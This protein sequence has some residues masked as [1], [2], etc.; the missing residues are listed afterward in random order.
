[1]NNAATSDGRLGKIEEAEQQADDQ[2][3]QERRTHAAI[4][5]SAE[6]RG[7]GQQLNGDDRRLLQFAGPFVDERQGPEQPCADDHRPAGEPR[8]EDRIKYR[9]TQ[10]D[11][12]SSGPLICVNT[13]FL[14]RFSSDRSDFRRGGDQ[15][16]DNPAK[17]NS[18]ST[19]L[20]NP[21]EFSLGAEP[22]AEAF[23]YPFKRRIHSD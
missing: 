4:I 11:W 12:D 22:T 5:V 3:R 8:D 17:K 9:N 15:P 2:P 18:K 16:I 21:G 14:A 13:K 1:M 19:F 20:C 6:Q 10:I 7:E 23:N